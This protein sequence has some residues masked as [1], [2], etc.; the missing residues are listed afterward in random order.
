MGDR[1]PAEIFREGGSRPSTSKR[2]LIFGKAANEN[3]SIFFD[4]EGSFWCCTTENYEFLCIHHIWRHRHK[5]ARDNSLVCLPCG[6]LCANLS[7]DIVWS[8]SSCLRH[9]VVC[10]CCC[11]TSS[12][13]LPLWNEPSRWRCKNWTQSSG[14]VTSISAITAY[15]TAYLVAA[16]CENTL[17]TNLQCTL[18]NITM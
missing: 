3:L 12:R 16:I 15:V 1:E 7:S 4:V 18:R 5:I 8:P 11:S 2:P 9:V 10:C 6:R 17:H 14:Y 13:L